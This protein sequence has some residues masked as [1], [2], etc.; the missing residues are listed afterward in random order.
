MKWIACDALIGK[1]RAPTGEW[2]SSRADLLSEMRRLGIRK[3]M[4][5]H[6]AA[7]DCGPCPGNLTLVKETRGQGPLLPVWFLTPDG[8]EPDFCPDSAVTAMLKSGARAAWTEPDAEGFSLL[9]WCSGALYEALQA[10]RVP[11]FLDYLK[12]KADDLDRVLSDF[13]GLRLILLNAPR[14]GRNR[15]LYPLLRRH[16]QL[17]LCLNHTYS[18]FR[19]IEDLCR[20]FGSE[21]WLFGMG[22]PSADG[23]AAMAAVMYAD[24]PD[25]AREAIAHGT[26]E[27]LLKEVKT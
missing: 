21:R 14:L 22:Y 13:P 1:P 7:L 17:H 11:L 16:P 25:A 15:L 23:G 26:L 8:T 20:L 4:V 12:I 10:R 19:G 3:A 9:P 2:V 5:R 6:A 24:I 18:V 27:R